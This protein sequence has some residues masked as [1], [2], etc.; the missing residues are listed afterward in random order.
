VC[1]EFH[2]GYFIAALLLFITEI[3]IVLYPHDSL[4]RPFGGDFLV[5]ILIYC[6]VK[7]FFNLPVLLTATGVLLFAYAVEISQYFHWVSVL[8]LQNSRLAKILLG[9]TFSF[10]DL[11]VYTLGIILVVMVENVKL[12]LRKF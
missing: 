7:S 11:L 6:F 5:V 4:V 8:G 10:T 12:S 3:T 2:I 9:T 1:Y